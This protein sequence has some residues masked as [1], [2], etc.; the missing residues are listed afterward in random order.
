MRAGGRSG[1]S[2]RSGGHCASCFRPFRSF[3][4]FPLPAH[5]HCARG[6]LA[7]R[8]E[9][10]A[11]APDSGRPRF[12]PLPHLMPKFCGTGSGGGTGCCRGPVTHWPS[13]SARPRPPPLHLHRDTW[14]HTRGLCMRSRRFWSPKYAL[15]RSRVSTA[16]RGN[17]CPPSWGGAPARSGLFGPAPGTGQSLTAASDVGP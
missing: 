6:S 2:G 12:Q 5:L 8:E 14:R 1:R 16:V 4:F 7:A 13:G 11:P 17:H 10:W 15:I 9:C 3:R